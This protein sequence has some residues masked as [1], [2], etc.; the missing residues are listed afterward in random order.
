LVLRKPFLPCLMFASNSGAYLSEAPFRCSTLR[1]INIMLDRK[2]LP[3]E[4]TLGY[5]KYIQ[6]KSFIKLFFVSMSDK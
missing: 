1:S 3:G 5:L 2:S 4:N 6:L